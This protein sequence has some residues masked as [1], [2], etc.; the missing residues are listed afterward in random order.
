MFHE[1]ILFSAYYGLILETRISETLATFILLFPNIQ[2]L[3]FQFDFEV[4]PNI[5]YLD[6][7]FI[8]LSMEFFGL[9][10]IS[11]LYELSQLGVS[12]RALPFF[13]VSISNIGSF[14]LFIFYL[15]EIKACW[16]LNKKFGYDLEFL[17]IAHYEEM[18]QRF[19]KKNLVGNKPTTN[20]EDQFNSS[21]FKTQHNFKIFLLKIYNILLPLLVLPFMEVYMEMIGQLIQGNLGSYFWAY[22]I[23]S[24]I[25]VIILLIQI[26]LNTLL[27]NDFGFDF[28]RNLNRNVRFSD[29]LWPMSQAIGPIIAYALSGIPYFYFINSILQVLMIGYLLLIYS[30]KNSF[31]NPNINEIYGASLI[32]RLFVIFIFFLCTILTDFPGFLIIF[33]S[34]AAKF[35]SNLTKLI[36]N[37]FTYEINLKSL[38][39]K[40]KMEDEDDRQSI[41]DFSYLNSKLISFFSQFYY[42]KE[43]VKPPF[44]QILE[45]IPLCFIGNIRE[46]LNICTKPNCPIL[47]NSEKISSLKAD[48]YLKKLE[49]EFDWTDKQ[50]IRVNISKFIAE[51]YSLEANIMMGATNETRFLYILYLLFNSKGIVRSILTL[52]S[53]YLRN[54]SFHER[55]IMFS[56]REYMSKYLRMIEEK[57]LL[58]FR[59]TEITQKKGDKRKLKKEET[60]FETTV[61]VELEKNFNLLKENIEV[62]VS[63]LKNLLKELTLETVSMSNLEK[64]GKA[65]LSKFE[66]TK[67]SFMR[68]NKNIRFIK[69]YREFITTF[70]EDEW[71]LKRDLTKLLHLI[72]QVEENY[73]H[74]ESNQGGGGF[75]LTDETHFFNE[76]S[77]FLYVSGLEKDIGK[78]LKSDE[79]SANLFGYANSHS[80]IGMSINDLMPKSFGS[81]HSSIVLSFLETGETNFI[82]QENKLFG[83]N[84]QGFTFP[85][86][87]TVKPYMNRANYSLEFLAHMKPSLNKKENLIICDDLGNIDC[88]GEGLDSIFSKFYENNRRQNLPIQ[89]LI[90]DLLTYFQIAAENFINVNKEVLEKNKTKRSVR[91]KYGSNNTYKTYKSMLASPKKKQGK[92]ITRKNE[93]DSISLFNNFLKNEFGDII[94]QVILKDNYPSFPNVLM[95]DSLEEGLILNYLNNVKHLVFTNEFPCDVYRIDV[96]I[97]ARIFSDLTI[98]ILHVRR[99]KHLYRNIKNDSIE[100]VLNK[101]KKNTITL[102]PKI[103]KQTGVLRIKKKNRELGFH[104]KGLKSDE[105][106]KIPNPKKRDS[107]VLPKRR[108]NSDLSNCP[109][110]YIE[111]ANTDVD[112][113]AKPEIE[114][115]F[116]IKELK[117]DKENIEK[118]ISLNESSA[119]DK[120]FQS[121]MDKKNLKEND[122]NQGFLQIK[123]KQ[124]MFSKKIKTDMDSPPQTGTGEFLK[125]PYSTSNK[126]DKI[127]DKVY[128]NLFSRSL[129]SH[130]QCTREEQ[131]FFADEGRH[132]YKIQSKENSF[133]NFSQTYEHHENP[134]EAPSKA[135][136]LIS[137]ARDTK[138]DYRK[139]ME[140]KYLPPAY[141]NILIFTFV[142]IILAVASFF[143][144]GGLSNQ[145]LSNLSN[146]LFTTELVENYKI[147]ILKILVIEQNKLAFQNDENFQEFNNTYQELKGLDFNLKNP[148][149]QEFSDNNLLIEIA[150]G[151]FEKLSII[152]GMS[153]YFDFIDDSLLNQETDNQFII[154]NGLELFGSMDNLFSFQSTMEDTVSTMKINLIVL[155]LISLGLMSFLMFTIFANLYFSH[156]FINSTLKLLCSISIKDY[157][158]LYVSFF[159]NNYDNEFTNQNSRKNVK[160]RHTMGP[161]D[162]IVEDKHTIHNQ[163]KKKVRHQ[164]IPLKFSKVNLLFLLLFLSLYATL[165]ILNLNQSQLLDSSLINNLLRENF[166]NNLR[167]NFYHLYS[168]L[169][170][171][172][173]GFG[174]TINGPALIQSIIQE[175]GSDLD[176]MLSMDN[177]LSG[178][179]KVDFDNAINNNLCLS[180]TL[181]NYPDLVENCSTIGNGILTKGLYSAFMYLYT[182]FNAV[183][184]GRYNFRLFENNEEFF[185][186]MSIIDLSSKQ[187]FSNS[188]ESMANSLKSE[189]VEIVLINALMACGICGILL[190]LLFFVIKKYEKRL[191]LTKKILGLIPLNMLSKSQ[192]IKKYLN[193]TKRSRKN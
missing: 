116:L 118:Q 141:K 130:S 83:M 69:V 184:D 80:M 125:P 62:Y 162:Q 73:E 12:W 127:K 94:L 167:M 140:Q 185:L 191:V 75:N 37:K 111:E 190:L 58:N 56:M 192:K 52:N 3:S 86:H 36:R 155:V 114:R 117:K 102:L 29:L 48:T 1:H 150:D 35:S 104:K 8:D 76:R 103:L 122:Y 68:A 186:I 54:L 171:V 173:L 146:G 106:I 46:H 63:R 131:K 30:S 110:L 166:F 34:L 180:D 161:K 53:L 153:L 151:N 96:S 78:I 99:I 44:F 26:F 135:S 139:L 188:I 91:S 137:N 105:E 182:N 21:F 2:Y 145:M 160:K 66:E 175:I 41:Q 51:I 15:F 107:V 20:A 142:A 143:S 120:D 50:D 22:G 81:K 170:D 108:R 163:V 32:F 174:K 17:E 57:A 154:N 77:C 47:K 97:E 10:R 6:L 89:V 136:S 67:A 61:F 24:F 59:E 93:I 144:Y 147:D 43:S 65:L 82:Y 179:E 169:N 92:I 126:N 187:Y 159:D 40:E 70:K 177:L 164:A 133:A 27:F 25:G 95:M 85:L 14:L 64:L 60:R 71:E 134:Y 98:N 55:F 156:K 178:S 49:L 165:F 109:H 18:R 79:N 124:N 16:D 181:N 88:F 90:P 33:L 74:A 121:K 101:L 176:N 119:S 100:K 138:K 38:A 132:L 115:R 31:F 113:I 5:K 4:W 148:P 72:N 168:L 193:A 129:S 123:K 39:F 7:Q 11:V 23:L 152:M 149:L 19:Q 189:S 84:K 42:L 157:K 9:S 45:E 158:T 183:V 87:I 128:K 172:Q 13:L 112:N 28:S